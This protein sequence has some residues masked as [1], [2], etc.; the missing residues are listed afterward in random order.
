[1][2][3]QAI[4]VITMLAKVS[5]VGQLQVLKLTTSFQKK[6]ENAEKLNREV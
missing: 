3:K 5:R 6:E 4:L 1:M 2:F